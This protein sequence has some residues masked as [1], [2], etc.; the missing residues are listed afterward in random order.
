MVIA[1][2]IVFMYTCSMM[3]NVIQ[4]FSISQRGYVE[5]ATLLAEKNADLN[6]QD[7]D[8]MS[9]IMF[10]SEVSIAFIQTNIIIIQY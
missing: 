2:I 1:L 6:L 3:K 8:G 10:A 9:A 7:K 4:L 5:L